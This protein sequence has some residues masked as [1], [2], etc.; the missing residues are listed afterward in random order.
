MQIHRLFTMTYLLLERRRMTAGELARRLEVSERTI[1]R[2]VEVLSAAGIP[3]YTAKGKGGGVAL[4]EDFVLSRAVL[5]EEQQNEILMGLQSLRAT[6][7]PDT[8]QTLAQLSALFRRGEQQWLQV[9]FS[10]WGDMGQEQSAFNQ[11]RDAILA[12]REVTFLYSGANGEATRRRVRPLVLMFRGQAWYLRAFC[13]LRQEERFFKLFRIRELAVEEETFPR[14]SLEPEPKASPFGGPTV[15][16]QL[17]AEPA[18]AF[19]VYDEFG[20]QD[21]QRQADGSFLINLGVPEGDWIYGYLLTFGPGVQV[22]APASIRQ[23]MARLFQKGAA[24]YAPEKEPDQ[25]MSD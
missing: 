15:H 23:G 8:G 16:L 20:G 4:M 22:L 5:T 21:V 14:P 12:C 9:D 17:L 18:M 25:L 10:G 6:R 24:I 2:D 19:R 11:L 3:I 1:R 7:M 13:L